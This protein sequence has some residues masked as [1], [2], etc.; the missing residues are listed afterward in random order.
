[1]SRVKENKVLICQTSRILSMDLSYHISDL[2]DVTFYSDHTKILY[3]T[4]QESMVRYSKLHKRMCKDKFDDV[5]ISVL[6]TIA[7][8]LFWDKTCNWGRIISLFTFCDTLAKQSA[9]K[10]MY[11]TIDD[12]THYTPH[13]LQHTH[14]T[15]YTTPHTIHISS[16]TLQHIRITIHTSHHTPP[17]TYSTPHTLNFTLD[18]TQHEHTTTHIILHTSYYTHHATYITLH[19]A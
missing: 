9:S 14:H 10:E 12:I 19:T 15:T 6:G 16:H 4:V 3:N 7:D 18:T 1:M 17:I 2:R 11:T 13:T 8:D 5:D